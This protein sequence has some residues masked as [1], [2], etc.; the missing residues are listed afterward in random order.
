MIWI[1][2]R[3]CCDFWYL[4]SDYQ[5]TKKWLQDESTANNAW[6][7]FQAHAPPDTTTVHT[8]RLHQ[9]NRT[10]AHKKIVVAMSG[11]PK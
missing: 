6:L 5:Q 8:Q 11:D 7:D 4:S 3:S 9:Y 2:V 10:N 1:I